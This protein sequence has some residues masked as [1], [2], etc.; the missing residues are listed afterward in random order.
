[1]I[2]NS[3]NQ[4]GSPIHEYLLKGQTWKLLLLNCVEANSSP[5]VR[6]MVTGPDITCRDCQPQLLLLHLSKYPSGVEDLLEFS[7]QINL[8][9][10]SNYSFCI[11]QYFK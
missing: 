1:M 11:E 6:V 3:D 5:M 10:E 9:C 8:C 7:F 2:Y 4:K